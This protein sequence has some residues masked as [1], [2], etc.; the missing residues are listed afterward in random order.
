M[1]CDIAFAGDI[2]SI[3]VAG[4][5]EQNQSENSM[6]DANA[7]PQPDDGLGLDVPGMSDDQK[8]FD[9]EKRLAAAGCIRELWTTKNVRQLRLLQMQVDSSLNELGSPYGAI[10]RS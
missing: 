7:S 3:H 8:R 5:P 1:N 4:V 10:Q 9:N 6:S 2:H